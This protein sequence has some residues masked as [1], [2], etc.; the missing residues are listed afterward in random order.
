[1]QVQVSHPRRQ[2]HFLP[3]PFTGSNQAVPSPILPH[4]VWGCRALELQAALRALSFA[5]G[6]TEAQRGK[7]ACERS[8]SKV[9]RRVRS[10]PAAWFPSA[11]AKPR[12][13]CASLG[14]SVKR[15]FE[16]AADRF[17]DFSRADTT[18]DLLLRP[19]EKVMGTKGGE[20]FSMEG[21][22]FLQAEK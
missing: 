14:L 17:N 11:S 22:N 3:Q 21:L 16:Q 4:S 19:F 2:F 9:N 5:D 10:G 8:H 15:H 12:S 18:P 6:K 1:M 13:L 20:K 7:A